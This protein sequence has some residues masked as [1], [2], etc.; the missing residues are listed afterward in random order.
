MFI[1]STGLGRTLLSGRIAKIVMTDVVPSTLEL[2]AAGVK[3]PRRLLV[4]MEITN[5]VHWTVRAFIDPPDLREMLKIVLTDPGLILSCLKF[6]FMKGPNYDALAQVGAPV[7][8]A[9]QPVV[10]K[11]TP[12][13]PSK[14]ASGP[15]P[16]GPSAIPARKK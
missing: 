7:A 13:A 3:E 15:G 5:P 10:G 4:E 6:L 9:A 12:A 2:P 1:R 11:A 14:A 8:A 16:A